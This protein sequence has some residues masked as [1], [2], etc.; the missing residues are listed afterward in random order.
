MTV[1]LSSPTINVHGEVL[2]NRQLYH[3]WWWTLGEISLFHYQ[4]QKLDF[5]EL[6]SM[7]LTAGKELKYAFY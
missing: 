5:M 1:T 2:K 7:E 4:S 3:N 6:D